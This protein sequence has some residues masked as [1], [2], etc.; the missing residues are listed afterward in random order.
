MICLHTFDAI[1][2]ILMKKHSP[3]DRWLSIFVKSNVGESVCS[4]F[5]T[6]KKLLLSAWLML[7]LLPS[8]DV[9]LKSSAHERFSSGDEFGKLPTT[10][11]TWYTYRLPQMVAIALSGHVCI[12][13]LLMCIFD[14]YV[15]VLYTRCW[16]VQGRCSLAFPNETVIQCNKCKVWTATSAWRNMIGMWASK[17]DS[18]HHSWTSERHSWAV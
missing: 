6:T 5:L 4:Y 3:I 1:P 16:P 15:C 8:V 9:H 2:S 12:S 14:V 13:A 7:S 11:S 17:L 18:E 10:V